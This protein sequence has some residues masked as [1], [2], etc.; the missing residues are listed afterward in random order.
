MT[1]KK[2]N[3]HAVG[4]LCLCFSSRLLMD[5]GENTKKDTCPV[6]Q[7]HNYLD[8]MCTQ[9]L[10]LGSVFGCKWNSNYFFMCMSP[11]WEAAMCLCLCVCILSLLLLLLNRKLYYFMRYSSTVYIHWLYFCCLYW[12]AIS[13]AKVN[14]SSGLDIILFGATTVMP[15]RPIKSDSTEKHT[16][17]ASYH[18]IMLRVM[19]IKRDLPC[20]S[21]AAFH[22][23]AA[24]GLKAA[25]RV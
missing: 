25:R 21:A 15:P 17:T 1:H 16:H 12:F 22:R 23:T 14:A 19:L 3:F 6:L 9:Q 4:R 10:L 18:H 20:H 7:Q 24:S 8:F 11:D 5:G 13:N 2:N